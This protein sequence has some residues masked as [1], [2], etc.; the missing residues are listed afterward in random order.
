M[1]RGHV[2]EPLE[3]LRLSVR[4]GS[5]PHQVL[6]GG[7]ACGP[8]DGVIPRIGAHFT[9]LAESVSRSLELQGAVLL[10]P[11]AAIIRARDKMETLIH[12]ENAGLPVPRSELI[13]DLDQIADAI[14]RVGGSPVVIKP[15]RGSQG[16]GVILAES[17]VSAL[18]VIESLLFQS[19]EF[20]IQ[21]FLP[22]EGD[23]RVLVLEGR[24]QAAMARE[25]APGEF[26]SNI[27]RG[28]TARIHQLTPR[29]EELA[30]EAAGALGLRCAGVDF[31]VG[32]EGPVVLE[33][34]ASPGLQGIET[35]LGEDLA[36]GWIEALESRIT[37]RV[38]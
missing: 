28:G 18:S 24:V 33:V 11:I 19:R 2:V 9:T 6:D 1:D 38:R 13:R 29:E 12:L 35:L 26:R 30:I 27:H 34:N 37:E 14:D 17:K 32:S 25:T 7:N 4:S 16:S 5:A 36:G 3:V 10:N 20:L 21:Q 8:F 22:S 31:L 15:L 23:I